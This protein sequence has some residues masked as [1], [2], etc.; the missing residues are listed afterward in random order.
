MK[1]LHARGYSL[2]RPAADGPVLIYKNPATGEEVR[3]MQKPKT[4]P[5]GTDPPE[6]RANNYY[7][8][9]RRG[10]GKREGAHMA[11]PDKK[12]EKSYDFK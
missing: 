6:K 10:V 8:R 1:E 3:I 9:Y 12:G 5:W 2:D 4:Q 7:Y 11:I